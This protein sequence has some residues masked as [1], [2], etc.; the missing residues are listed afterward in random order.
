VADALHGQVVPG[1]AFAGGVQEV[2][3]RRE[4]AHGIRDPVGGN[5]ALARTVKSIGST[6]TW[7]PPVAPAGRDRVT[8]WSRSVMVFVVG[9]NWEEVSNSGRSGWKRKGGTAPAARRGPGPLTFR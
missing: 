8:G 1:P 3:Q 9:V 5:T 7:K 2:L 6:T 4:R